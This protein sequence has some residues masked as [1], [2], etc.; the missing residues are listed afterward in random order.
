MTEKHLLL[1]MWLSLICPPGGSLGDILTGGLESDIERIYG[2]DDETYRRIGVTRIQDRNALA[3]KSTV[4][5]SEILSYCKNNGIG[6]LCPES[7]AY[8]PRLRGIQRKPLI[9]YFRGTLPDLEDNVCIAMVGTR[10]M[11][12]YGSH[13]AY[14]LSYD[15]ARAGAVIVSGMAKGIDG[16]SHRGCLDAGGRTV[17]VFGCGI[18]RVYPSEHAGLMQEIIRNGAVITE[19]RPFTRP[20]GRNFPL[21]NRII[22]GLCQGTVVVEA[23]EKS[24]ALITAHDALMQGRD[25]FAV[26]GKLGEL[27]SLGTNALI[28]SGA[29]I[30]TEAYDIL[31]EY[32]PLYRHRIN[33]T[34]I[35]SFRT[36]INTRR[37]VSTPQPAA[38]PDKSVLSPERFRRITEP[39][40]QPQTPESSAADS[41]P[42]ADSIP[43]ADSPS[44][45]KKADEASM[46]LTE[47]QKKLYNVMSDTTGMTMDEI[48]RRA[49]VDVSEVMVSMTMMEINHAV[50]AL[51]G[52]LFIRL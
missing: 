18:D 46:K 42:A 30:A 44:A 52:G 13:A 25:L 10:H 24:G 38:E 35:P 33:L 43:A 8:P 36:S 40:I 39:V 11:T 34:A 12:E 4:Q 3:D 51:P 27:N 1:W 19:F 9:L 23:D 17:A 32:E 41:V 28:R 15:M 14:T 49:S 47:E 31:A 21:R 16:M 6:V 48:A 45:P 2:A 5:A 50:K 29:K 37:P 7:D 22:S 26:P 20:E